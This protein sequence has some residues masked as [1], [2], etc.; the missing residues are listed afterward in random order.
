MNWTVIWRNTLGDERRAKTP[1]LEAALIQADYYQTRGLDVLHIEG[2]DGKLI[3]A[4]EVR[5]W[6]LAQSSEVCPGTT[7]TALQS[8]TRKSL[9]G[10][11][12]TLSS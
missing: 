6:G 12:G 9:R 3:S 8:Q 4:D 10:G 1:S 5:S 7:S 2:P 11:T